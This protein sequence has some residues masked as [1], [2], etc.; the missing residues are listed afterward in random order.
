MPSSAESARGS[1][2]ETLIAIERCCLAADAAIVERD[3][4]GV[5]SALE[6]QA[7]LTAELAALF[8]AAPAA[9]PLGDPAIAQRVRGILAFRDDQLA[10]LRAYRDDVSRRLDAIGRMR[11]L[12]RSIGDANAPRLLNTR[13]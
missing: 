1:A 6:R 3:W 11:A 9:S 5:A 7:A 8:G 12:S 13:S 2:L 10:R 4:S